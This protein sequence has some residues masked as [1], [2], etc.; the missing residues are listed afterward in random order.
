MLYVS[1]RGEGSISVIDFAHSGS[2]QFAD[3]LAN[4]D[5]R[6]TGI[7]AY[8]KPVDSEARISCPYEW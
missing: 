7:R 5:T 3:G 2:G 8:P 1:N 6:D 4:S